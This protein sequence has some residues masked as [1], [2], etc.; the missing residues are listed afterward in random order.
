MS[1]KALLMAAT[2]PAFLAGV[3]VSRLQ[4]VVDGFWVSTE[5]SEVWWGERVVRRR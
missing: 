1:P 5:A 3:N 4:R 2:E